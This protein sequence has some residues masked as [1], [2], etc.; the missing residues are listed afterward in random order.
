MITL[1]H[2]V[3]SFQHVYLI[4]DALDECRDREHLLLLIEE[5]I[6]WKLGKVHI[7]ATSHE[8]RDIEDCV[9]PLVS[10]QINLHSVEVNV[11]IH[12]PIYERLR[13]DPKLKKWPS[14]IHS[15]I[16]TA[17]TKGAHGM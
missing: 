13:N 15:Q 8:E 5:I 6:K 2:I 16:E 14:K 3:G 4:I 12:T 17:L 7:L 1:K 10:A 9:G 11:D